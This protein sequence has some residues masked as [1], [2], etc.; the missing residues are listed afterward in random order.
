MAMTRKFLKAMGIEEE[1]I[2]QIIEAHTETVNALKEERDNYK[3]DAT[4]LKDVQRE[5]DEL[6][7]KG[8]DGWKEK[9]DK[10]K[11]EF[12]EYKSDVEGKQARETKEKATRAYF[13][14]AGITGKNLDIAMRGSRTEIDGLEMD[15]E[16]IKDT[17]S[18]KALVDGDFASLVATT[19]TKGAKTS[20][21][22]ANNGKGTGKTKEEIMAI[23]DPATR[24]AEI[25][26]NPEAFGLKFD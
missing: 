12:D 9:H 5:L 21:P 3:K 2:E 24:Q 10:V 23:K 18:L 14:S 1:K 4:T 17:A 22:P 20:N 7:A 16:K 13:E 15:G 6:K 11:K 19:T 25:A 26:K 8:D